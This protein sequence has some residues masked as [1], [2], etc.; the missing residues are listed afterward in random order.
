MNILV[1]GSSG[2]VA[3]HVVPYM[4]KYNSVFGIDHSASEHTDLKASIKGL[5]SRYVI[6]FTNILL[7][8]TL[9]V[10]KMIQVISGRSIKLVYIPF[11]S[12]ILKIIANL[13]YVLG[14]FG[15]IDFKLTPNRVVKL[16]SDTS[17]SHIDSKVV[18]TETY[19]SRNCEELSEILAKFTKDRKNG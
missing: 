17:Y 13:L 1:T 8:S 5:T 3:S 4:K 16:F 12:V 14:F 10:S 9:T 7:T 6:T 15:R 18:D 2:Y 11:F 19:T